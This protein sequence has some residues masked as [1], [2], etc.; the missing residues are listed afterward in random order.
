MN[1]ADGSWERTAS[2]FG[3]LTVDS[4]QLDLWCEAVA[5]AAAVEVAAVV[6]ST[7]AE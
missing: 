4:L 3:H 6:A 5:A 2:D 1:R 7:I